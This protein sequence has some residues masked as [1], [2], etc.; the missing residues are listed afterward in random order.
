M[1]MD[2]V[3]RIL[4]ESVIVLLG[5][6]V[7]YVATWQLRQDESIRKIRE[8]VKVLNDT[9]QHIEH[10]VNHI[11]ER[12]IPDAWESADQARNTLIE[13]LT[14]LCLR[15]CEPRAIPGSPAPPGPPKP[16]HKKHP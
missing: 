2:L 10:Y 15:T 6:M 4:I 14:R 9:V 7:A 13:N 1:D 12:N 16:K 5:G 8:E 3:L 11:V